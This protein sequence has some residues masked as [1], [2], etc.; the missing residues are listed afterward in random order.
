[1]ARRGAVEE[2]WHLAVLVAG[3]GAVLGVDHDAERREKDGECDEPEDRVAAELR[4]ERCGNTIAPTDNDGT[5]G[6]GDLNLV[7]FNWNE[8]GANLP[9]AWLNSRPGAGTLVGL[10]ELNQVLFNWGQPGS[11]AVVPEPTTGA[12]GLLALVGICACRRKTVAR[13]DR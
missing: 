9:P 13:K 6:L 2:R 1:M 3:C 4:D 12:L 11:L 8:D 10:P 5:W 7:L